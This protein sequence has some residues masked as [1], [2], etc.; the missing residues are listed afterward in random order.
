MYVEARKWLVDWLRRQPIGPAGEGS[1]GMSSLD[2]YPTGV[3]HPVDL[4]VSGIDPTSANGEESEPALLD[5][6]EE[7]ARRMG[8]RLRDR[9]AGGRLYRSATS[10]QAS[11]RRHAASTPTPRRT[12]IV[13]P[14]D[15]LAMFPTLPVV[16]NPSLRSK[17]DGLRNPIAALEAE[18]GHGGSICPIG[19]TSATCHLGLPRRQTVAGSRRPMS[20]LAIKWTSGKPMS[21]ST[22]RHALE[23]T[24][25]R[26]R[27]RPAGFNCSY[28]PS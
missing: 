11:H 15:A 17:A 14:R 16:R 18:A 19:L 10:Y 25:E 2:R 1:L 5:E 22:C 20:D 13:I 28:L 6:Q 23:T 8:R 3:L 7:T 26:T 24:S 27:N 21:S 4:P 9:H 12:N